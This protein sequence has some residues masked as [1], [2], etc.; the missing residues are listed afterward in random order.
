MSD[1]EFTEIYVRG[2]H[3]VISRILEI[4]RAEL[5][6]GVREIDLHPRLE[7]EPE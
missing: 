4:V 2:E 7:E 6:D 3:A 5:G 1:I